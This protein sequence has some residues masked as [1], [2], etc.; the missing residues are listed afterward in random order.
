MFGGINM[1][2]QRGAKIHWEHFFSV[3]AFALAVIILSLIFS[4]SAKS[5]DHSTAESQ[6]RRLVSM[7]NKA[8]QVDNGSDIMADVISDKSFA[9]VSGASPKASIIPRQ[10]F[11][12]IFRKVRQSGKYLSYEHQIQRI[13]VCNS[14]AYELGRVIHE[15][16]QGNKG[17]REVLNV[18]ALED[19]G[20]KLIY[21]M[22]ADQL[23][24]A[25]TGTSQIA[26]TQN[27]DEKQEQIDVVEGQLD[28][29]LAQPWQD[30]NE[31]HQQ[32][33]DEEQIVENVGIGASFISHSDGF[34][35]TKVVGGSSAQR[36]GLE[37][38]DIVVAVD[39]MPA[40]RLI[41]REVLARVVGPEGS[42]IMLA[43]RKNDNQQHNLEIVREK[44]NAANLQSTIIE[45]NKIALLTFGYINHK[46]VG[47]VQRL[48][49]EYCDSG[50]RGII[51]DLRDNSGG[52][53]SEVAKLTE[54]F[55][56]SGRTMWYRKSSGSEPVRV[57]SRSGS[58]TDLPIVVLTS[59]QTSGNTELFA[60]ALKRNR[61]AAVIG[62]QTA[63]SVSVKRFVSTVGG[64]RKMAQVASFYISPEQQITGT[65]VQP[66]LEMAEDTPDKQ[67][68][69]K[70]AEIIQARLGY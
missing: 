55:L 61:T 28:T 19:A 34:L 57:F 41:L 6:I 17:Q 7:M 66:D 27:Q 3:T 43:V 51:I 44:V 40:G 46:T 30:N 65:G 25:L 23:R 15:D 59:A 1:T 20:W 50:V 22:R 18:F 8:W 47:M 26:Q 37:V 45:E 48:L 16:A 63:G 49:K 70:A 33:D 39:Q 11:L 53:Y 13:T 31:N 32:Y 64:G 29:D 9:F 60:A 68:F 52:F 35:V 36:A 2:K 62:Q 21:T 54:L 69:S 58:R 10:K 14:I 56:P 42:T 67:I 12:D 38:G 4:Q 5:S 24:Q